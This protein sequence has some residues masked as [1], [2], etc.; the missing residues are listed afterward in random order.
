MMVRFSEIINI[1][2]ESENEDTLPKI[3]GKENPLW[4]SDSQIL[5]ERGDGIISEIPG[6]TLRDHA[7]VEVVKY[8]D[9][10][11]ESAREIRERVIKDQGISPSPILAD[12]HYVIDNELIDE[13]N[14]YAMSSPDNYDWMFLH[15]VGV[16]LA[17]L[18][19]GRGMGY[20][21]K[22]L[23]E[24]GLAAFLENVGMYKIPDFI[25]KKK[26]KLKK[27]E[28]S[29]IKQHPNV[30]Y[31]ILS[32]LGRRYGWLADVALQ[33]HE[34]ADGSGY[35]KGLGG[36][37]ILEMASIIGL[38]DTYIAM[39]EEKP[40]REKYLQSHAVNFI[41]KET[42]KLFPPQILKIFLNQI[43]LFPVNSYVRLNNQSIGR[44]VSTDE[45]QPLRPSIEVLFDG[46]S[47][48]VA[49]GEVIRLSDNPLLYIIESI[50]QRELP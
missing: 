10:F 13:M 4:F 2:D 50:D 12:L 30:S 32:N 47:N 31:Q 35:P 43:S 20:D 49:E 7:S 5:T 29:L 27:E 41:I 25:H 16:T 1:K 28:I 22:G 45:N 38:I 17:S 44:V 19:I 34:R 42:K 48:K 21:T 6:S 26:E 37:E 46:L 18:K 15:T 11:I 9:K 33:V 23:L 40:Y 3:E 36:Q 24:L 39:T 8:F 14:E